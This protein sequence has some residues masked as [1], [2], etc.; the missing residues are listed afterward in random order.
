MLAWANDGDEGVH[1]ALITAFA[2]FVKTGTPILTLISDNLIGGF[3][4]IDC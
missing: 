2:Q 4:C 3:Q 1:R